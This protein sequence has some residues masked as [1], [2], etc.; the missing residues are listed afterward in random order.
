M[1]VL[2]RTGIAALL[3]LPIAAARDGL[4]TLLPYWRPILAFAA[5]EIALPW[6]LLGSAETRIS[7]SLTALLIAAV[8][9]VG[10]GIALVLVPRERLTLDRGLGLLLGMA[11]VRRSS[12]SA[13]R[14]RAAARSS[15]SSWSPSATPS[16]R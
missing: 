2:A 5:I 1:L 4:R 14:A 12:G 11:G 16:A 8:P 10:T 7:S 13:S 15:R 9:L 3:L 6:V